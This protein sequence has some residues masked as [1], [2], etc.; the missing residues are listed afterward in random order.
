M[1]RLFATIIVAVLALG[2]AGIGE[3][4][5]PGENRQKMQERIELLR[6]LQ[7]MEKLNLDTETA[8]KI[9]EIRRKFLNERNK[10][11][12]ELHQDFQKLRQL[13]SENPSEVNNKE[14]KDV[15]EG[16][17]Q[18]RK[19]LRSGWEGQYDEV[20]KILT[21][22]QQAE[23]ILFLKE[24]NQSIR[25]LFRRGG[26]GHPGLGRDNFRNKFGPERRLP[27]NGPTMSRPP[28]PPGPRSGEGPVGDVELE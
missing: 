23:L 3:S 25:A 22:R 28:L 17:R 27:Q 16:I 15:V 20:S 1:N 10:N 14:L 11:R 19:K 12:Q 24:F 21:V 8:E 18:K 5:G 2:F 26:H 7:M 13:L 4:R 6:K 9:F